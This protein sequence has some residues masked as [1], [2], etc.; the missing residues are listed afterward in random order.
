[1]VRDGRDGGV[2]ELVTRHFD[3]T[4]AEFDSIYTGAG[5]GLIGRLLDKSLRRD[6]YERFR[7]T[8]EAAG[9][10]P[11]RTVL[12]VGCGTGRFA[13]ALA[14]RGAVV[15]GLDPAPS[16]LKIAQELAEK[17]GVG[18][19]CTWLEGDLDHFHGENTFDYVLGIGLFDYLADPLMSLRCMMRLAARSVIVTFPRRWTYRAPIRKVRLALRGCPVFFYGRKDVMRLVEA[20]DGV[21]D[22]FEVVGKLYFLTLHKAPGNQAR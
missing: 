4:A 22:R 3:L 19:R 6:M 9:E 8:I 21:V 16:M 17:A 15:V 20:A 2:Q 5:K 11:G 12:D 7:L 14:E 10:E 13:V 1:M 18:E